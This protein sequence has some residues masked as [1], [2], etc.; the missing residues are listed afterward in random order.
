MCFGDCLSR[1]KTIYPP[2]WPGT[3]TGRG[4]VDLDQRLRITIR[5][6]LPNGT[7]CPFSTRRVARTGLTRFDEH[8]LKAR[9]DQRL[10]DEPV[11]AA[12]IVDNP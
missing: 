3:E 5:Q 7:A 9:I 1:G 6:L 8:G 12:N 10:H 4:A 11:A 2:V